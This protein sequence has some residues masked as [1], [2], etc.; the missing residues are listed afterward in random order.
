MNTHLHVLEAFTTLYRIWPN[1]NLRRKII[2]LV[3]CFTTQIINKETGSLILFFDENWEAKSDI[4]SYGHDIEA[5]WLL[6]EAAEAV[7][8]EALTG[9][10]KTVS[11]K[12]AQA[13]K[14]G[15]DADGGLWYEYEPSRNHLVREKHWWVQAEAMVGFFNAWQLSTD[16]SFLEISLKNWESV[17]RKII[18]YQKGEWFWGVNEQDEVMQGEDKVGVWKCPYHNSRACVELIKRIDLYP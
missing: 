18:N 17:K 1:E 6:L 14:N 5:A 4:V 8:D 2:E 10:V 12:M 13:A 11:V 7:H 3:H 16:E 9:M 15:L